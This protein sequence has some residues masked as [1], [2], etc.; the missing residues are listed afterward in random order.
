M[1]D[2]PDAD[3]L[4]VASH[5]RWIAD[6]LATADVIPVVADPALDAPTLPHGIRAAWW[7]PAEHAARL[8]HSGLNL[9][10]L[11]AGTA[12]L[13]RVPTGLLGRPVWSGTVDSLTDAPPYGWCKPAETKVESL[14]AAW[15][16]TVDEFRV[17]LALLDA[18]GLMPVQ[19]SPVRLD[20]TDEYRC[21]ITQGNVTAVGAYLHAGETW[22]P[23]WDRTPDPSRAAAAM[24]AQEVLN[25]LGTDQP[26]GFVLDVGRCA[27]GSWVVIEANASWSSNI[28]G[29]GP[30]AGVIS[31]IVAAS[32]HD[33][34]AL[35]GTRTVVPWQW[36]PDPW[37]MRRT[38]ARPRLR[39]GPPAW[40]VPPTGQ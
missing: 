28:Y 9:Q 6:D 29:C 3:L 8:M 32:T 33:D 16:D 38:I 14:P 35:G 20:L 12:W 1:S 27:N 5:R 18:P 15:Y 24:F 7:T 21:F 2:R 17:Q 31:S 19:V 37:I 26:P 13:S 34:W 11:S 23:A 4:I 30:R 25:T 40:T 36:L 22:D 10:L 39:T